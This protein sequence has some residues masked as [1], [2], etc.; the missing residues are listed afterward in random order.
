MHHKDTPKNSQC[1]YLPWAYLQK[2]DVGAFKQ[3]PPLIERILFKVFRVEHANHLYP[4]MVTR[5]GQMFRLV[6]KKNSVEYFAY[7]L[8]QIASVRVRASFSFFLI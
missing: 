2:R 6:C 1:K 4:L 3:D 5:Y 7:S 8:E